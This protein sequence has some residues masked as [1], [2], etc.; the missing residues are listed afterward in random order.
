VPKYDFKPKLP[1][2]GSNMY[3]PIMR[4]LYHL[5]LSPGCR[6][7]RIALAEKKLQFDMTLEKVWESREEFLAM[8]PAG[9]VPVLLEPDGQCVA[10]V[11]AI[12]EYLDEKYPE[13]MLLGCDPAE[14]SET[15]RLISWFDVKFQNEVTANLVDEKI[16]KRFLQ[17][18]EPS[19]QTIRA[20]AANIHYHLDYIGWLI[21]ERQWLAGDT[22]TYAD[23][24]AAAHLSC[25]D[26]LGDVPWEEHRP[27]K[28]WYARVKSRPSFRAILGDHIPGYPPPKHYA[29]PDF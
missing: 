23:I 28:E 29:D 5:W 15:R 12:A 16:M 27:A 22:L 4:T 14:R 2:F 18:G 19:S 21:D 6:K 11:Y 20:G 8:N 24:T 25:I 26:Y 17:L 10:D 13:P 3:S 9:T 7:T 1:F